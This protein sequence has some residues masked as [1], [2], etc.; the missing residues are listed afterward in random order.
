MRAFTPDF[1]N[2]FAGVDS[3]GD[4][5]NGYEFGLFQTTGN[6][7]NDYGRIGTLTLPTGSGPVIQDHAL[8]VPDPP[9][10]PGLP[11]PPSPPPGQCVVQGSASEPNGGCGEY[12]CNFWLGNYRS[13]A[14]L[15]HMYR[16]DCRGCACP[17]FMLES[18]KSS[19]P[20][21]CDA[22]AHKITAEYEVVRPFWPAGT[23]EGAWQQMMLEELEFKVF[24][25]TLGWKTY[26]KMKPNDIA[27]S[28]P[29]PILA[30]KN[31]AA[32]Q[33]FA[34]HF[35]L[36][37]ADYTMMRAVAYRGQGSWNVFL[38][39]KQ[40]WR[41]VSH[42]NFRDEDTEVKGV[43]DFNT[44]LS[45]NP[46]VAPVA[47]PNDAPVN[48]EAAD[49]NLNNCPKLRD[50][51]A[52]YYEDD[53]GNDYGSVEAFCTHTAGDFIKS[54]EVAWFLGIEESIGASA[55]I[56][57]GDTD[58]EFSGTALLATICKSTS[59]GILQSPPTPPS[60]PPPPPPPFTP[61]TPPTPP[62]THDFYDMAA[63][64]RSC[65]GADA[66]QSAPYGF[67][68]TMYSGA[69]GC[70]YCPGGYLDTTLGNPGGICGQYCWEFYFFFVKE[71]YYESSLAMTSTPSE[72]RLTAA[73]NFAQALNAL[74]GFN[75]NISY[76]ALEASTY[77]GQTGEVLVM[78]HV[79]QVPNPIIPGAPSSYPPAYSD[80]RSVYSSFAWYGD[81]K[82]MVGG[83]PLVC[84]DITTQTDITY[85]GNYIYPDGW[86]WNGAPWSPA[87]A[88]TAEVNATISN[89]E[90]LENELIALLKAEG[91]LK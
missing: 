16:C 30:G 85:S 27:W 57:F 40:V 65:Y 67:F 54:F 89:R 26:V 79:D 14:N 9:S 39:D 18:A 29:D 49:A 35:C 13:C 48:G 11:P 71:I 6:A 63:S 4:G 50:W 56:Y 15:E 53:A 37:E 73:K 83:A 47:G 74:N 38:D 25:S 19:A 32:G 22:G 75:T 62:P 45:Y 72:P 21:T 60:T 52:D 7:P 24:D 33:K 61:P 87:N 36:S 80:P 12:S 70:E 41:S 64:L 88:K 8:Y 90:A 23:P 2:A 84:T 3:Y 46:Y 51:F 17:D 66:D 76:Q 69:P 77:N 55:N 1:R 31:T 5:W 78:N 42:W 58:G 43:Y 10:G 86:T 59:S 44:T 34:T 28:V 20:V 82:W 91:K 81:S 68:N